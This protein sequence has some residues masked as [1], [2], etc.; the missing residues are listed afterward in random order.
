MCAVAIL[1][2]SCATAVASASAELPALYECH[3]LAK[4]KTTKKYEGKYEDKKCS[5]EAAGHEGKYELQEW[6]LVAKKNRVK[7]FKGAGKGANLEVKG[8][9]GISCTSS[10]VTGKFTGPKT[11]GNVVV[12]FK[13]C[14]TAGFKCTNVGKTGEVKTN[15]LQGEVGYLAGKG[16]KTPIV[17]SDV[18]PEAPAEYL[19]EKLE[20]GDLNVRVK[21]SVIGEIGPVNTFSKTATFTYEQSAGKQKWEKFETGPKDTL[22][23]EECKGCVGGGEDASAEETLV[24]AKGEEL[25]LKA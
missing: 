9:S 7:T 18:Q 13:G 1:G 5:K 19:A 22:I 10:A 11:A 2:L 6:N 8:Q 24:T 15:K 17:G 23:T 16:T 3:K 4:S 14:E 21:G 20:C 25:E 12:T